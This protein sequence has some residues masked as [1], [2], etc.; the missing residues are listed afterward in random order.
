MRF[1]QNGRYTEEVDYA[2][3]DRVFLRTT[4][5]YSADGTERQTTFDANGDVQDKWDFKRRLDSAGRDV[6]TL[7]YLSD[8]TLRNRMIRNYDAQ[9]RFV[10]GVTYDANGSVENRSVTSYDQNGK[11]KEFTLYLADGSIQFQQLGDELTMFDQSTKMVSRREKRKLPVQEESDSYGNW[12]KQKTAIT[13]TRS[14]VTE[15]V[16][17]IVSRTITYY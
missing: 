3:N 16:V 4:H 11:V 7:I 2:P 6:E 1:D 17:E 14:G 15:E 9:G 13:I 5:E 8:G 12:T 10:E